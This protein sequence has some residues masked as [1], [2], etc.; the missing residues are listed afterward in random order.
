MYINIFNI[1]IFPRYEFLKTGKKR[2]L[3]DGLSN[4]QY[5]ILVKKKPKLYTW[6]LARLTP[7]AQPS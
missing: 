2:F 6:F 5:E 1:Y 4:L 7:P 3:T